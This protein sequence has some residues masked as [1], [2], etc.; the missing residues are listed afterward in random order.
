[1]SLKS[2]KRELLELERDPPVGLAGIFKFEDPFQCVFSICGPQGT[3]YEG[4]LFPVQFIYP[5]SYPFRAP[6]VSFLC[7]IINVWCDDGGR[8]CCGLRMV[9]DEWSPATMTKKVLCEII[10]QLENWDQFE[11]NSSC[12]NNFLRQLRTDRAQFHTDIVEHMSK[13]AFKDYIQLER[14]LL[15]LNWFQ[16][17]VPS[18]R[19]PRRKNYVIFLHSYHKVL[20]ENGRIIC[21]RSHLAIRRV[22]D[23]EILSREIAFYL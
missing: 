2:I 6:K 7:K 21:D 15:H 14:Y 23:D 17:S 16:I 4:G 19:W 20:R 18:K 13:Y 9:T 10:R 11:G 5:S 3:P 12:S 8:F 1:M 22:L